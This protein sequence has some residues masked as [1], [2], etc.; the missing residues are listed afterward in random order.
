[1]KLRTAP[2]LINTG[3]NI[4]WHKCTITDA[5]DLSNT[6]LPEHMDTLR[7]GPKFIPKSNKNIEKMLENNMIKWETMIETQIPHYS[8]QE[9]C[10][11]RTTQL[12][13]KTNLIFKQA[14]KGNCMVAMTTEQ[15]NKM[16]NKCIVNWL[17]GTSAAVF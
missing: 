3:C 1:M 10:H 8:K 15:Y 16:A 13:K 4:Y 7:M 5:L 6:L 11:A 14:D 17:L 2:N 9:T 12:L